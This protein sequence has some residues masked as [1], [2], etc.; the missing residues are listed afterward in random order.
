MVNV[1]ILVQGA[2]TNYIKNELKSFLKQNLFFFIPFEKENEKNVAK[3]GFK[4][5]IN[6]STANSLTIGPQGNKY[7][8][9]R[10]C[11]PKRSK[12]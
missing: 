7:Q 1:W 9:L 8:N 2:D 5:I 4:P 6:K 10:I 11:L 3:L 12:R